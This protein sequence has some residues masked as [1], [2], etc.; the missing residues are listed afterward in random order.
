MATAQL[1]N[2]PG[3]TQTI[4]VAETKSERW[5]SW[6]RLCCAGIVAVIFIPAWILGKTTILAACIQ[7]AAIFILAGYSS[8]YLIITKRKRRVAKQ[9]LYLMTFFD[10]VV[11]TAASCSMVSSNPVA[12]EMPSLIFGAYFVAIAFTA[13]HYRESLSVFSSVASVVGYTVFSLV[14]FASCPELYPSL[15]N[16]RVFR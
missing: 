10:V 3:K 12:G 13:F 8:F 15:S 4:L 14:Q 1:Q 2:L 6:V 11:I 9:Y 16:P 5:L 7:A